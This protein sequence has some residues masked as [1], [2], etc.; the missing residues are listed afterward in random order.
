[1]PQSVRELWFWPPLAVPRNERA[2]THHNRLDMLRE[3]RGVD[4][5]KNT[6]MGH[7]GSNSRPRQACPQELIF[8]WLLLAKWWG[9]G[10]AQ[11]VADNMEWESEA[12]RMVLI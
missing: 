1:M 10:V 11:R 2:T 8:H 7:R 4:V 5:E 3:Y 9:E 12:W 6:R